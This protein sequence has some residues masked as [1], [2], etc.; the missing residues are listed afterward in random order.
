MTGRRSYKESLASTLRG[1]GARLATPS[2]VAQKP[3]HAARL[4]PDYAACA[5]DLPPTY[6]PPGRDDLGNLFFFSP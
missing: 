1:R 3:G 6:P 4:R 2:G 5:V